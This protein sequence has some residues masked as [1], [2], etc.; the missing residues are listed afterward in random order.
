MGVFSAIVLRLLA[1]MCFQMCFMPGYRLL[2]DNS[3]HVCLGIDNKF[4]GN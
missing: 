2:K 4:L 1:R 3:V